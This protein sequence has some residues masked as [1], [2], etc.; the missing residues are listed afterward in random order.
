MSY[1]KKFRECVMSHIDAGENREKVRV[2][3]KLGKNTIREWE[4]LRIETGKLENRPLKR[5]F[6][7]IDPEKLRADVKEHPDDF[8]EERAARFNC[9][10]T[11]I[12]S[13]RKKHNI[14]R[15][16]KTVNYIERDEEERAEYLK[17]LEE[18]PEDKRV[19]IDE[20]GKNTDLDRTHGYAPR[21]EPVEGK[22]RGKKT[23]KLNIV[24]AKCGDKVIK[25]LNYNC[26]MKSWLF[27]FWFAMLLKCVSPGY[28][29]IMDNATFHRAKVLQAM[30]EAV[31]CH[32]LF[33]PK[34]S[35]DL[36]PIVNC[37]Q[38]E[39]QKPLNLWDI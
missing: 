12:Q 22:I 18:I 3:F 32:V 20:T 27:E 7:K 10:R 25:T 17:K 15:K 9:S 38:R 29:F 28:W 24:G 26:A 30:A 13:S 11:G 33:L 4:K 8:D 39:Q 23:E 36:N 1:D 14:T 37:P 16:K 2:M 5:S 31:G 19:Y 35:P 34:Y 21:G 6:R